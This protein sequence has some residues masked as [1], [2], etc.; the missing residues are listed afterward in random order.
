MYQTTRCDIPEATNIHSH[1]R[2]SLQP[3]VRNGELFRF[4]QVI[5]YCQWNLGEDE[6]DDECEQ[7][8]NT[9]GKPDQKR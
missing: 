8:L 6:G 2:D 7:N 4:S 9:W 3:D 5:Q 1:R